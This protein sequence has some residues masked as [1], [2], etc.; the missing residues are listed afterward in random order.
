MLRKCVYRT[1]LLTLLSSAFSSLTCRLFEVRTAYIFGIR[2]WQ[3]DMKIS[4]V[5]PLQCLNISFFGAS[6]FDFKRATAFCLG[7]RL[8]KHK[9]ARYTR[10]LRENG[11]FA[12]SGYTY[13]GHVGPDF[14]RMP[15]QRLRRLRGNFR[16]LIFASCRKSPNDSIATVRNPPTATWPSRSSW[17]PKIRSRSRT[18]ARTRT[19]PPRPGTSSNRPTPR[20]KAE[21][22]RGRPIC[23]SRSRWGVSFSWS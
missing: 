23:P 4:V 19:S 20:R 18:I 15:S 7:Q 10:N 22:C 5:F 14:L 1:E 11:P 16:S 3:T 6:Y 2:H 9:T 8:S 13:V 12:P 17:W 21:I